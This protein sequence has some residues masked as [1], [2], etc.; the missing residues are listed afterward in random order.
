MRLFAFLLFSVALPIA[1]IAGIRFDPV[2]VHP[3]KP[4]NGQPILLLVRS[5]WNDGCGGTLDI[6]ASATRIDVFQIPRITPGVFCTD[7]M[8]PFDELINPQDYLPANTR[9]ASLVEVRFFSRNSSLID[10]LLD[11]DTV[12]FASTTPASS[13]VVSGSFS[14]KTLDISGLFIDQQEGVISALLSD[15]DD[16]GRSSWR[17]GAGKMHGDVYVGDLSRY[18][19]IRCITTPC[20]RAVAESVGKINLVALNANELFVSYRNAL[21]PDV[22]SI[23]THR[24]ERVIFIRSG[25]LP[26]EQ[27]ADSWIPDLVGEWLVG[28]TGTRLEN[29]EFKRY[30]I[31]YIGRPVSEPGS[32]DRR[33]SAVSATNPADFFE[34]LCRDD[35]P[36]DGL[37]GCRLNNYRALQRNCSASFEP[38]DVTFGN[39]R[40]A[41]SCDS[42]ETEF[43]MQRLSR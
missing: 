14:A 3:A 31:S 11:T 34:I 27:S 1:A 24:Y 33:F 17:F 28:V 8:V 16:Q 36:V 4:Q 5:Y 40:I 9:F 35:R 15:Y 21:S 6:R 2:S 10:Q 30:R 37:Q 26:G 13:N 19:Q 39:V 7:A 29:A 41:A 12:E 23:A 42:L 32:F 38:T 18:Q 20:P 25:T 22:S 43:V